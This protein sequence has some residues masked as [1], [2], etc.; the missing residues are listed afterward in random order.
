[1]PEIEIGE[2]IRERIRKLRER[3]PKLRGEVGGPLLGRGKIIQRASRRLDTAIERIKS[4]Q[5]LPGVREAV[6]R[7]E[8]GKR[9]K[10]IMTPITKKVREGAAPAPTLGVLKEKERYPL[11]T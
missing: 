8:P 5:V 11:R 10:E 7:W 9:V 2:K 1:M 4:R 3:F 6:E